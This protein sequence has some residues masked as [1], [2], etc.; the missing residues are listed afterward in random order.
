MGKA[1]HSILEDFGIC[2]EQGQGKVP[3]RDE[4]KIHCTCPDHSEQQTE[5]KYSSASVV[6]SCCIVLAGKCDRRLIKRVDNI[7][8]A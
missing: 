7:K 3:P 4:E 5:A 6:F 1:D 2:R 8:N